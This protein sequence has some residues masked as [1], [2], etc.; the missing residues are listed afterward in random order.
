MKDLLTLF[1]NSYPYQRIQ[2]IKSNMFF[3]GADVW[4]SKISISSFNTSTQ[5]ENRNGRSAPKTPV[6][7]VRPKKYSNI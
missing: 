4:K 2:I 1:R 6:F 7:T 5:E 3:S